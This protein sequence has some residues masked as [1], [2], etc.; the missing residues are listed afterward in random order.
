MEITFGK[1]K[2]TDIINVP[3]QY[4]EWGAEKLESLRWREV[5]DTELKRRHE[6]DKKQLAHLKANINDPSTLDYLVQQKIK[7][8]E[9]E[10]S[11]SGCA[12]EYDNFNVHEEAESR[13]KEKLEE[14]QI[15]VAIENLKKE[16]EGR[17]GL[18][19]ELLK[20]IESVHTDY[21]L[22][23]S[24]FSSEVKY[25]LACEYVKK[26]EAIRGY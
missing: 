16:F 2:G 5:F 15:E 23:R 13:A 18:T 12:W 8:V 25:K 4:L 21:G 26:L 9:S 14:L 24:Q 11:N 7:E 3:T 22:E 6:A 10:I 20:K 1:H 19:V 17:E